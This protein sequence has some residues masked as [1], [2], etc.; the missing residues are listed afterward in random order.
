MFRGATETTKEAQI[1]QKHKRTRLLRLFGQNSTSTAAL[2]TNKILQHV[3]LEKKGAGGGGRAD[4]QKRRKR[5]GNIL[6]TSVYQEEG[7]RRTGDWLI[8]EEEV[9]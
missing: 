2:P 5:G 1:A 6:F 3:A 8:F 9:I 7:G 4:D